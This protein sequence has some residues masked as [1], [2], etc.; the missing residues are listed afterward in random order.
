MATK[1]NAIRKSS[2]NG[3]VSKTQYNQCWY[4]TFQKQIEDNEDT[5]ALVKK[6]YLNEKVTE[7]EKE[8]PH[9]NSFIT[10]PKFNKLTKMSFGAKVKEKKCNGF[11]QIISLVR[12]FEESFED[13][14]CKII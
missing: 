13:G 5:N 11:N 12:V 7:I 2:N 8:I 9:A 4:E 14:G 1:V 3:I 10:S 6:T